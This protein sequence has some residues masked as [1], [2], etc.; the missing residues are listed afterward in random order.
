MQNSIIKEFFAFYYQFFKSDYE[1][2]GEVF[3]DFRII[4]Q[5]AMHLL[6]H[7]K[8]IKYFSLLK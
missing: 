8:F 3:C 7:L 1:I 5:F 2:E 4:K 6:V